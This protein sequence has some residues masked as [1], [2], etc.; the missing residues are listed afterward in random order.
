MRDTPR[1]MLMCVPQVCEREIIKISFPTLPFYAHSRL[2]TSIQRYLTRSHMC[3]I[4]AI[5]RDGHD[6]DEEKLN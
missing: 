3:H 6:D 2:S 5:E 4:C 1:T